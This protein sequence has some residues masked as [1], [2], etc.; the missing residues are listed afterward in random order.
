[1][2]AIVDAVCVDCAVVQADLGDDGSAAL[3]VELVHFLLLKALFRDI[4]ASLLSPSSAV[5]AAWH[6]L[7]LRPVLYSSVCHRLLSADVKAPRLLDHNPAGKACA[8]RHM[9]YRMTHARYLEVFREAPP[10]AYWPVE[11]M[12]SSSMG[13]DA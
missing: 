10:E 8:Q 6:A 1:M 2:L 11:E 3:I 7:I 12:S 13:G 4:D 9:R 5:D